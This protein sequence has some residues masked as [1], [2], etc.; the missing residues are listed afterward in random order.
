VVDLMAR[1]AHVTSS[2]PPPMPGGVRC[3]PKLKEPRV[4]AEHSRESYEVVLRELRAVLLAIEAF[5]EEGF[6]PEQIRRRW[7][8]LRAI[9]SK[10]SG[11]L[12]HLDALD[13]HL[14]SE[15]E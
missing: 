10:A 1:R 13:A 11:T 6:E 4:R 15:R 2:V 9:A 5:D 12:A 7:F 8:E 3:A 14:W